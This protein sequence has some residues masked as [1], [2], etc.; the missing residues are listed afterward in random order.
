MKARSQRIERT[1][2]D[3]AEDD[4][5]RSEGQTDDTIYSGWFG[6]PTFSFSRVHD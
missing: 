3:V 1:R 4:S 2:A 6:D 5:Q